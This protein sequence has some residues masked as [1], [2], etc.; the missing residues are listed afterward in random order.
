MATAITISPSTVAHGSTDP[1]AIGISGSGFAAGERLS[2][3]INYVQVCVCNA[4]LSGNVVAS[5]PNPARSLGCATTL[6][7][8]VSS[9]NGAA[10]A[11]LTAT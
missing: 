10:Q 11:S 2:F 4:D 6:T 9:A 8:K 3:M 5:F 1:T 7:L